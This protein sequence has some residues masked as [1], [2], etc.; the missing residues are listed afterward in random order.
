MA[1]SVA[2]YFGLGQTGRIVRPLLLASSFAGMVACG[3]GG[4]GSSADRTPEAFTLSF[5]ESTY[6]AGSEAI[7]NTITVSGIDDDTSVSI[8]GGEYSIDGAAFRSGSGQISEGETLQI[9]GTASTEFDAELEVTVTVGTYSETA[10]I[11]TEAEDLE[12]D[13]FDL[14]ADVNV[15]AETLGESSTFTVSG[16]N[17]NAPISI[18]NG[19]FQ[20]V[21]VLAFGTDAATVEAGQDVQVRAT[22]PSTIG[23]STEVTLTIGGVSDT[24]NVV[25]ADFEPPSSEV[26]FPAPNTLSDGSYVTLRG[27]ASDDDSDVVEIRATVTTDEGTVTVD[28]QSVLA[29]DGDDFKETWSLRVNLGAEKTNTIEVLAVD[30][31]GNVQEEAVV[32]S[33]MQVADIVNTNFPEG[34][35]VELGS[36]STIGLDWDMENNRLYTLRNG[37]QQVLEIDIATS[38]RSVFIDEDPAWVSFSSVTVLP[39][40]DK[41]LLSDQNDGVIYQ[42]NLNTASYDVLSDET[43]E[44]SDVGIT[45]PFTVVQ[46]SNGAFYAVDGVSLF[47]MDALS[48]ARTLVSNSDRPVDGEYPSVIPTG[49]V[50]DEE[51]NKAIASDPVS[52]QIFNADLSTG[53]RTILVDA[54]EII[55]PY[56]IEVD[57]DERKLY[58]PDNESQALFV[59]DVDTGAVDELSGPNVP[60]GGANAGY[61]PWSITI[62]DETDIGF[63]SAQFLFSGISGAIFQIDLTTGERIILSNS[64]NL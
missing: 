53:A 13:S 41:L 6:V 38:V 2:V 29:A 34:N 11:V 52:G 1:S 23:E 56:Y 63:V 21:G 45:Y 54:G 57:L 27:T 28:S 10:T 15:E 35:T 12:P 22:A 48:G 24:V 47:S 31:F 8:S 42:A 19:E 62:D 16:I 59:V 60:E 26:V 30:A 46:S 61:F 4:G 32:L 40:N 58:V 7:S 55:K 44:G 43:T 25:A 5:P 37:P 18:V 36:R 51:A 20:I 17:S 3:G 50:L 39:E 33:V 64:P 14:G 9:S 49:L